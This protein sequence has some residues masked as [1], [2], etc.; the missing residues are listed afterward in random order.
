M[1]S[2]KVT[3]NIKSESKA[4]KFI[5]LLDEIPYVEVEKSFKLKKVI[6]ST[7]LPSEYSKPIKADSY[8]KFNREEIYEDRIH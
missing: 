5:K 2:M 7:V 4:K 3:I 8:T 1:D 6:H